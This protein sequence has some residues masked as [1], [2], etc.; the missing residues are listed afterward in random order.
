MKSNTGNDHLISFSSSSIHALCN[1]SELTEGA[2][3]DDCNSTPFALNDDSG[4][5]AGPNHRLLFWVPPASRH[6]FY[7][8]ETVLVIPRGG[9]ELDLRRM[10]HGRH[11]HN[12]RELP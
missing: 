8:P 9:P 10:A 2:F 12:C 1:T 11:W 3:H 4:W 6:L 7:N 5:V